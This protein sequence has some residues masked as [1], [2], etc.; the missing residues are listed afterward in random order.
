MAEI[1]KAQAAGPQDRSSLF[2]S[3]RPS[4][5]SAAAQA[6]G[7]PG[8]DTIPGAAEQRAK[9]ESQFQARGSIQLQSQLL[10]ASATMLA[11]HCQAQLGTS[12][13]SCVATFTVQSPRLSRLTVDYCAH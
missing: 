11:S 13:R 3:T 4:S 9:L 12:W 8:L 2:K 5:S 1:L 10:L 6:S 7:V